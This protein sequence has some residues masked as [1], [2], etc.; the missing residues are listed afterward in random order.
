M[1]WFCNWNQSETFQKKLAPWT[2]LLMLTQTNTSR[3]LER[4]WVV[5][6]EG[7]MNNRA[8]FSHF[9]HQKTHSEG[10]LLSPP[11]LLFGALLHGDP[12]LS[13]GAH[14]HFVRSDVVVLLRLFWDRTLRPDGCDKSEK[15]QV[16]LKSQELQGQV[17]FR[18]PLS[19]FS[20][21]STA[22]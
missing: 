22:A 1:K 20:V 15:S 4:R 16:H 17:K 18:E 21:K 3:T 5:V 10:L 7:L 6:D 12:V 9:Q 19:D 8:P 11:Y 14:V 2:D 13:S